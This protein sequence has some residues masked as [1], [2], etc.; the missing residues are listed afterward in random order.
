MSEKTAGTQ[1]DGEKAVDGQGND[2]EPNKRIRFDTMV[3]VRN[4]EKVKK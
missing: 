2:L 1:D 3:R 4:I